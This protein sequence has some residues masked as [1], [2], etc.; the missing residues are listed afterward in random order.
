MENKWA[1]E[2]R[3]GLGAT[4]P[5]LRKTILKNCCWRCRRRFRL[6]PRI[7]RSDPWRGR[8]GPHDDNRTGAW[9]SVRV[10]T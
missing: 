8:D 1:A 5:R 9:R 10:A 4:H 7:R 3:L 2:V 6:A